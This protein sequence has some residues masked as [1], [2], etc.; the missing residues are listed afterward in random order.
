MVILNNH[1]FKDK[2]E[3]GQKMCQS[4][5]QNVLYFNFFHHPNKLV[6]NT[7]M[8][9][10]KRKCLLDYVTYYLGLVSQLQG[11][12]LYDVMSSHAV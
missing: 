10:K 2:N 3:N 5:S 9:R 1:I 7:G 8:G 12:P 11:G 4:V 6:I